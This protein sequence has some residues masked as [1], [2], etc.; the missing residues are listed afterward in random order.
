V[1]L[2]FCEVGKGLIRQGTTHTKPP[3]QLEFICTKMKLASGPLE[4]GT[5][6]TYAVVHPGQYHV[7]QRDNGDA[8]LALTHDVEDESLKWIVESMGNYKYKWMNK[9]S[10]MGG[11]VPSEENAVAEG[12]VEGPTEWIVKPTD[13]E[14]EYIVSPGNNPSLYVSVAQNQPAI[15]AGPENQATRFRMFR[16]EDD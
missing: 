13:I 11:A 6:V 10:K 9:K 15:H 4:S 2:T 16:V 12:A 14:G 3:A 8:K 7:I 1:S 5:Y